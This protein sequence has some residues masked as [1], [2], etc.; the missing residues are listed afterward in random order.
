MRLFLWG[1]EAWLINSTL[2]KKLEVFLPCHSRQILKISFFQV[3]ADHIRRADIQER[4]CNIP[5]VENMISSTQITFI[6]RVV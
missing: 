4:F 1:Y 5:S 2:N 3:K 6:D